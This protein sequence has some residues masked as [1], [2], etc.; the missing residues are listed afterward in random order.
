LLFFA[1][2]CSFLL[3]LF[4]RSLVFLPSLLTTASSSLGIDDV[5][6]R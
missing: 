3:S 5:A 1:T 2:V 4:A 6:S